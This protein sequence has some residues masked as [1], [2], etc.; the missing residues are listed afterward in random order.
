MRAMMSKSFQITVN[1]G[2]IVNDLF[3]FL[4]S[5]FFGSLEMK[6]LVGGW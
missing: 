6:A 1:F 2:E 5:K 3:E 4:S